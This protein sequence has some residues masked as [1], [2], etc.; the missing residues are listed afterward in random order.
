[1]NWQEMH[2]QLL[3]G[4]NDFGKDYPLF[5]P[6]AVFMAEYMVF[7]LGAGMLV[8]WFT[9]SRSNR[10]MVIQAGMAFILAE[11]LG[12]LSG[13]LYSHNQPFAVFPEINKLVDHGVDNSFPSDH[14][15]LFFSICFSILL[16]RKKEGW[17]WV[18][19]ALLVGF[20]RIWVGVH[21]PVDILVGA[22]FGILAAAVSYW[23]VPRLIFFDKLLSLYER[24]EERIWPPK[25]SAVEH[26]EFD[27]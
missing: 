19:A 11:I 21:Y 2:L 26:K 27:S 18:G 25:K 23:A 16:A 9:R 20:S 1:M 5:N 15:I 6:A 14:T 4:I 24:I 13:Q 8:Y 10:F 7:I 3:R 22:A 12:K 17:L